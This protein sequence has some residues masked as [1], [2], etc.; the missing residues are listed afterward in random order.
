MD[1]KRGSKGEVNLIELVPERSID[2][3]TREG[4]LVTILRPRFTGR[5]ARRFLEPRTKVKTYRV[6]LDEIGSAV[7]NLCDGERT[8]GEIGK[9]M[10]AMFGEDIEPCYDRLAVFFANL[11]A[12]G[13]IRYVNMDE[14]ADR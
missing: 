6:D 12:S 2:Y 9:E 4:T 10:R 1:R 13:F 3:E 14:V 5:L 11:E 7:W 8:V